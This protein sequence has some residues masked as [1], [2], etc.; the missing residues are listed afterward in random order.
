MNKMRTTSILS[1][2]ILLS[3]LFTGACIQQGKE[4]QPGAGEAAV[5]REAVRVMDLEL[6]EVARS[7]EYP[8]NLNPFEEVHLA[9]ASPGRIEGIFADVGDRVSKGTPLG[10][11][12]PYTAAS[13]RGSA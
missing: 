13:V 2:V 11:N 12:G 3:I 6:K 1:P 9:P 8:A 4:N 10:T 7:V 5:K